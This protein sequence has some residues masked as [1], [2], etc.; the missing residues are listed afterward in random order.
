M[1]V[2][3]F[4]IGGY[5]EVGK[6][7]TAIRV[8]DEVVILD[9]GLHVMPL[10]D[11]RVGDEQAVLSTVQLT[12]MGA[13]PDDTILEPHKKNVKA[14]V[15]GHAHLDHIGAVRY[16]AA[17]YRA[18]IIGSPY[19]MAILKSILDDDKVQLPNKLQPTQQNKIIKISDK[20]K[21]ELINITHS[22]LQCSIVVLHTAKGAIMYATDFKLDNTPVLGPL[23]NYARLQQLR[24]KVKLL[25]VECLYSGK[26]AKTP[27]ELIAR[28]ML[29]EIMLNTDNKGKAVFVTTFASQ[30]ARIKSVIEF[31][32]QLNR[33]V[34]ILGRSMGRYIRAAEGLKLIQFSKQAKV[35]PFSQSVQ[36]AL[37][38][39]QHNRGKYVVV[40]TGNQAEPSSIL[41]K[42][43]QGKYKFSFKDGDQV[44]FSCKTIP[45]PSNIANREV[46]EKKLRHMK[47]RIFTDVHS[48]GHSSREDLREFIEMVKP[49]HIIPC[50]GDA[51]MEESL[52]ILANEIGYVK[53]KSIHVLQDGQTHKFVF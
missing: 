18:P 13:I 48:S 40:C 10:V 15:L 4:A 3:V 51:S 7:M 16:L 11:A 46:L 41:D 20:L 38:D 28:D 21:V 34:L 30:I 37:E 19:A 53:G 31:G 43:I 42:I 5:S 44:I 29:K 33:T 6:N 50:H 9:I 45:V 1:E 17:K 39:V 23:P 2:E 49:T 24:G 52:N 36:H 25:I 32:R 14:I 8:D 27:S 22:T 26:E 35:L 47:V 12:Q